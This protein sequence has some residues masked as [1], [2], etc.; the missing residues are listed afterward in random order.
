MITSPT[1]GW[2]TVTYGAKYHVQI[3]NDTKFAHIGIDTEA[4]YPGGTF[5]SPDLSEGKYYW[6]VQA[7]NSEG[8]YG[9]YSTTGTF[10]IDT[11]PPLAPVLVSP[12][13]NKVVAGTTTFTWKPVCIRELLSIRIWIR[14]RFSSQYN[15][16]CSNNEDF[17]QTSRDVSW[18]SSLVCEISRSGWQL[19]W[20]EQFPDCHH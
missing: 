7:K 16:P 17:L 11:T 14:Q 5:T 3:A 9:K 6:R 4:V 10:T 13:N 2:K 1:L 20:L 19:E 8:T 15:F 12:I 18:S